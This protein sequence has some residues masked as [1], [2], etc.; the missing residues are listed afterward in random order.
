MKMTLHAEDVRR[1]RRL[2]STL[3]VR[4]T[5]SMLQFVDFHGKFAMM[6]CGYDWTFVM[7]V[8]GRRPSKSF[9]IPLLPLWSTCERAD[10]K[11]TINI[12][13][14]KGGAPSS[15]LNHGTGEVRIRS[16]SACTITP[17]HRFR[18]SRLKRKP[19]RHHS[20]APWRSAVKSVRNLILR[21]F[22]RSVLHPAAS[23]VVPTASECC[24]NRPRHDFP[25]PKISL[26]VQRICT[27]YGCMNSGTIPSLSWASAMKGFASTSAIAAFSRPR[28][29]VAIPICIKFC[30]KKKTFELG[31]NLIPPTPDS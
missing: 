5:N 17:S 12:D 19:A 1:F 16:R 8:R 25:G 10:D 2:V 4:P 3:I 27:A 20:S 11:L 23:S 21:R 14:K 31:L 29:S 7:P 24:S 9:K 6:L 26:F 30:P 18:R 22:A 15:G 13:T 28:M